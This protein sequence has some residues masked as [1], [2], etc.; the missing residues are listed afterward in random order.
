MKTFE[1]CP[2]CG[3]SVKK[4]NV[5]RHIT[6]VHPRT[7]VDLP[8]PEEE[9][10]PRRPTSPL[11]KQSRTRLILS[12]LIVVSLAAVSVLAF[13]YFQGP[14]NPP[15]RIRV[16]PTSFDFGDIP[17]E[18][19]TTTIVVENIGEGEL[20]LM[21]I[22]TSCMCTSAVLRI[23]GRVSPTFGMHGNPEGWSETLRPGEK[24]EL[25]VSYDPNVHPDSG[26]IERAVYIRS[27]D[28]A[29]QE[30]QIA[31]TANVVRG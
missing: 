26:Y 11:K 23:G 13:S 20:V 29:N 1:N 5:R 22:S 25:T 31:I 4:E 16:T 9:A 15:P 12:V 18:L 14:P 28:P 27:N 10:T 19:A 21:A 30:A 17:P 8:L 7:K 2:V 3:T 24:G 6:K